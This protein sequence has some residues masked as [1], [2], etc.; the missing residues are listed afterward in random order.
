MRE[1]L[2]GCRTLSKK[3]S[4]LKSF[5]KTGKTVTLGVFPNGGEVGQ[6]KGSSKEL[7]GQVIPKVKGPIVP[8][9]TKTHRA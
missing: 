2:R 9:I 7:I 6:G 5:W 1:K 4:R 8:K 3:V